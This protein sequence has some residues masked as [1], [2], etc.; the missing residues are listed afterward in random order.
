MRGT[1]RIRM[2]SEWA[3]STGESA[4]MG[5]DNTVLRTDDGIPYIPGSSLRGLLRDAVHEI[6]PGQVPAIFGRAGE[7]QQESLPGRIMVSNATLAPATLKAYGQAGLSRREIGDMLVLTRAQTAICAKTGAA[8]DRSLR[9]SEFAAPGLEFEAMVSV[10]SADSFRLL[11]QASLLVRRLGHS[12]ARGFGCC[13][14]ALIENGEGL[15]FGEVQ[16]E[17]LKQ[18]GVSP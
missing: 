11:Q 5:A 4:G 12:R 8:R 1:L 13:E 14:A 10:D 3:I 2:L 17:C 18:T 9:S 15:S 16:A 7:E 6:E